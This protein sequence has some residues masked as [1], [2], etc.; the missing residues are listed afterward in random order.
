VAWATAMMIEYFRPFREKRA[1]LERDV[2]RIKQILEAGAERA[3]AIA[4]KTLAR[5]RQAVGLG[6]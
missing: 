2:G 1:E 3:R 4:R 5:A 6:A